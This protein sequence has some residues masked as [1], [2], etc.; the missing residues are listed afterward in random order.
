MSAAS[1]KKSSVPLI[2]FTAPGA[3]FTKHLEPNFH[4]KLKPKIIVSSIQ[5]VNGTY[6]NL[7]LMVFSELYTLLCLF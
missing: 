3:R 2:I 4:T 5:T 6:E 7:R 1:F